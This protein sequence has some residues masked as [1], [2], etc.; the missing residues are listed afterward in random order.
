MESNRSFEDRIAAIAA[1]ALTDWFRSWSDVDP[2]RPVL[3]PSELGEVDGA[4]YVAAIRALQASS[5]LL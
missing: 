5:A 1:A 3:A 2:R 4:A